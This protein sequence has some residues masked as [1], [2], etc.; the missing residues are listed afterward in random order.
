VTFSTV[1]GTA[2]N[3]KDYLGVQDEE[4]TFLPGEFQHIISIEVIDDETFEDDEHFYIKLSNPEDPDDASDHNDGLLQGVLQVEVTIVNDDSID[5]FSERVTALLHLNHHKLAM[6]SAEW[7]EHIAE[8]LTP[9]ADGGFV[10]WFFYFVMLP[11]NFFNC[12]NPPTS[13]GGAWP[14]FL[15]SLALVGGVTMLIGD[16]ASLFG[17]SIGLSDEITAIT[18][19][20]LGTSL[21]DTFASRTA[22]L[23]EKYADAAITNVTGSNSVNVFLG[24]GLTWL[25]ASIYHEVNSGNKFVV[26]AGSLVFGVIVFTCTSIVAM[27]VLHVQRAAGGEL[28]GPYRNYM[29]ALFGFMW[30]LYIVLSSL[31]SEDII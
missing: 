25:T 16:M 20:A 2:T 24:L 30:I 7:G 8:S 1:E 27:A 31:K 5:T 28:G 11:F 14:A 3:N 19:V 13:L 12:I 17:C 21:P 22:A 9:P 4:I 29:A 15:V 23:N 26:K 10:A 18:F 6:G